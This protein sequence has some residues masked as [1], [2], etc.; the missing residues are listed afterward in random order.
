MA[1][2]LPKTP[3]SESVVLIVVVARRQSATTAE[4]HVVRV[5]SI[6]RRSGPVAAVATLV[7]ERAAVEARIR[8][9]KT[10]AA[11]IR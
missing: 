11:T 7:D 9:L 8:S 5:A 6:I 4:A 1:R 10:S 2:K 3:N